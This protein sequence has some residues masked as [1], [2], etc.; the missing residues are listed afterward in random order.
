MIMLDHYIRLY[1]SFSKTALGETRET[2]ISEISSFLYCTDRNSKLILNRLEDEKWIRWVPGKGRG[3]RSA[4]T[5]LVSPSQLVLDQAK[6]HVKK[7]SI[8]EARKLIE[9]YASCLPLL[10][11]QFDDWFNLL[12]GYRHEKESH[13]TLRLK[14]SKLPVAPLDPRKI[15][16]RSECHVVQHVCDTLV[17]F[18]KETR[19][20]D[21]CLAFYWESADQKT[22]TFYLR[23]GVKFH[24]GHS[25]T[26]EDVVFT[27]KRL[28]NKKENLYDWM[29][30]NLE[31][32]EA[33]D[34]YTIKMIL[35][36]PNYFLL[37]LLCDEHLSILSR[38]LGSEEVHSQLIGTGPFKISQN[39]ENAL[40]LS[41]NDAYFRERPFLDRVEYWYAPESEENDQDA[42]DDNELWFGIYPKQMLTSH[43][44]GRKEYTAL[45]WNVQFLSLNLGKA[46]PFTNPAFRKL[47][48]AIVNPAQLINDLGGGREQVA[49]GFLPQEIE[50]IKQNESL[51]KLLAE[52]IYQGESLRLYTFE[53]WDHREDTE[54]IVNR[55]K[56]YGITVEPVFLND[57]ELL[58]KE[59]MQ[60]AD[61]IH[62][63]A[64]ISEQLEVSFLHLVLADNSF[65]KNHLT[66]ELNEKIK[67]RV[68]CFYGE[69][70][71]KRRLSLLQGIQQF[72]LASNAVVPLY[73]NEAY[74]ATDSMVQNVKVNTQGWIDISRIWFKKSK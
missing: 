26:A 42:L 51:E 9:E 60:E 22:W 56:L 29:A 4:I 25:F 36:T 41:A 12:F 28:M 66:K 68:N 39:N 62:D 27:F 33:L 35:K 16:L 19:Q 49:A 23:K 3:H 48:K 61:I 59:V 43:S 47:F 15:S 64:T 18:N 30:E 1:L 8:R 55:C 32:V 5:F 20:I 2:L 70:H 40:I 21:P 13:D 34:D 53:E 37:D 45:E 10:Q 38:H 52:S 7:G 57:K 74:V 58:R 73:R 67:E 44:E 72:L 17:I 69:P 54:W 24:D 31:V 6:E 65:I 63:S 46:G 11:E 14:F 71:P 50:P